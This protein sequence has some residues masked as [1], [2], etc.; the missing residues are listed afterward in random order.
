VNRV[1]IQRTDHQ[2]QRDGQ[3]RNE[4][5]CEPVQEPISS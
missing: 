5:E 3:D 1:R 4:D 2:P